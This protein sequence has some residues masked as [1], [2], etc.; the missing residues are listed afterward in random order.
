MGVVLTKHRDSTGLV[1][2]SMT[3]LPKVVLVGGEDVD[4]RLELMHHLRKTYDVTALGSEPALHDSFAAAGFPYRD[5]PLSR[6]AN[7]FL[8]L[9]TVGRLYAILRKL[10][11]QIV[12]TFDTK[13]GVWGPLAAWLAG[14]P[15][16][17]RTITGLGS[18]YTSDNL[19]TRCLRWI[20]QT[21]QRATG[22]FLDLAIFQNH[23]DAR[24]LVA[25]GIVPEHKSRVILGSGVSTELFT[26][27]R[28]DE[29]QRIELRKELGVG[30][31]EPLV[32]MISRIIRSKGVL[33]LVLAA[34]EV[35]HRYPN[36]RFLLV[37]PVDENSIDRLNSTELAQLRQTVICPGTRQDIPTVLGA[38]DVFVLPSAYR[39]GIPR[40]LLEAA[41]MGLPIV[42]TDSPGCNEVVEDAVNGFLIP[43]GA[44]RELARAILRLLE[45]P[46][47][48]RSFGQVSRQRAVER[49]DISVIAAQ[50]RRVYQGLLSAAAASGK[51]S[52]GKARN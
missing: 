21:L 46:G 37:G 7:P 30:A 34:Q 20:Y 39:E 18:L 38:S 12:H 25:A 3:R 52:T 47:L 40:V 36:T 23:D 44:P 22:R 33:D 16:T 45:E 51:L 35:V 19:K 14:V 6:R 11:P 27:A 28:V 8:D 49:F 29:A 15:I 5:Y 4:A 43:A 42:T 48:R 9:L 50:T 26:P 41:A 10:R 24:Q 17:V 1:I 13:P 31:E 32:T 2:D